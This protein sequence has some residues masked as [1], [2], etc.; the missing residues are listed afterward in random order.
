M[1]LNDRISFD[2]TA[3]Q[4]RA[5]ACHKILMT[6]ETRFDG[7]QQ[8]A[9]HLGG[10]IDGGTACFGFWVPELA[11][12]RVPGGD[13][14]LEVLAPLTPLDL[15]VAHQDVAFERAYI[16]VIRLD[17]HCFTA[18]RGMVAGSRGRIGDFYA[19]TWRD[20]NDVWHRILDPL[21]MSLPFGVMAPAELYDVAAMQSARTDAAY[22]Q[23]LK[24]AVPHK[25]GPPT[26]ILQ[27]HVPSATAGGTIAALTRQ[28]ERLAER[29]SRGLPLDPAD[30]LFTGYDSVQL[31]PV[32]PTTVYET[33][34]DFWQESQDTDTGVTVSLLRP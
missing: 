1:P 34:P 27:I 8:I 9:R 3:A 16:P 15:T 31:L 11:E 26:N 2:E 28:F 18:V 22:F 20:S 7:E 12:H 24:G 4:A 25:F 5:D 14:F 10:Q 13:V 17:E 6:A 30:Q 33:G 23:A 21:A 32:E 19:L 29:V